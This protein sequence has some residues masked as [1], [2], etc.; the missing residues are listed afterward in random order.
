MAKT[1]FWSLFLG[2]C[3]VIVGCSDSSSTSGEGKD[4]QPGEYY[5]FISAD[6]DYKVLKVLAV[7]SDATHV[8]YYNNTF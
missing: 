4:P 7:D 1:A 2:F 6:G 5:W 8:C 3:M